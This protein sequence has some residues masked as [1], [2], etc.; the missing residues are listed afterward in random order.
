MKPLP[1]LNDEAAMLL[2][3]KRSALGSA[4]NDAAEALRDACTRLQACDYCAIGKSAAEA[5]AALMR[6]LV[7]A[8][9]WEELK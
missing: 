1:N 4:R 6:L 2:R 8:E 5:D 3:G 7:I 9:A